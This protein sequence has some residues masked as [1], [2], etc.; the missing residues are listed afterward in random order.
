MLNDRGTR[1]IIDTKAMAHNL[2]VVQSY[3]PAA[4][5]LAMIKANAYGHGLDCAV[6][7]F[8]NAHGFGVATFN[9]ATQVRMLSNKPIV[10]LEGAFSLREWQMASDLGISMVIATPHQFAWAQQSPTKLPIWLKFNSGMHRLG[11]SPADILQIAKSL[12]NTNPLVLC[13]HFA[14][15][16]NPTHPSNQV[17]IDAFLALSK[18]LTQANIPHQ[19]SLLNSAGIENF[20]A[21]AYDWVRAGIA[22]YGGKP[23]DTSTLNLRP[24]M[25]LYARIIATQTVLQGDGVGYGYSWQAPKNTRI[26]IVGVGYGDGY[27]RL[28][29]GYVRAQKNGKIYSLNLAGRVSMDMLAVDLGDSNL[30]I[31]DE[32]VLL[33][34]LDLS[35]DDVASMAHTI[36][37]TIMCNMGMR[38]VRT[39]L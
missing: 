21:H 6:H 2:G 24:T 36:S 3:V 30:D 29:Q 35:I 4:K 37:Y 23:S 12:H 33:G 11:L 31:G 9:E 7:G 32:I 22:L 17:Q 26:G 10:V 38:P 1:L 39:V 13:S 16:D 15:A 20:S 34:D 5:L 27:P 8:A 25:R 19:K 28:S 14:N 18:Q